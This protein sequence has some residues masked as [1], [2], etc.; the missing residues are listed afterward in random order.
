MDTGMKVGVAVASGYLLGRRRKLRWAIGVG[1]WLLGQKVPLTPGALLRKG[2]EVARNDPEVMDFFD[3]L[4]ETGFTVGKRAARSFVDERAG[5]LTERLKDRGGSQGGDRED[6]EDTR[7]GKRGRER[8]ERGE[9]NRGGDRDR[10][11]DRGGEER[12]LEGAGGGRGRS[13]GRR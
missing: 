3:E 10:E 6:D 4:K 8:G 1:A 12:E 13:G 2:I 7:E 11:E 9:R 5:S